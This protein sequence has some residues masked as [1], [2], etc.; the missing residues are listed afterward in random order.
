MTAQNKTK[1]LGNIMV[2]F[3]KLK[4]NILFSSGVNSAVHTSKLSNKYNLIVFL[5]I[6]HPMCVQYK[7]IIV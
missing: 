1:T 3:I 7:F 2:I 4:V 5:F 6:E